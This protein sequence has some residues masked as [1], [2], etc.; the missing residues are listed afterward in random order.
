MSAAVL[1]ILAG[2]KADL[3]LLQLAVKAEDPYSELRIRVADLHA[4]TQALA[5]ALSI[6]PGEAEG[7]R[8]MSSAPKEEGRRILAWCKAAESDHG[9]VELI[10]TGTGWGLVVDHPWPNACLNPRYWRNS[11][12]A[13]LPE[14][15]HHGR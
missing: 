5:A 6:E 14:D 15:T 13:P 1:D 3:D 4:A 10:W 12:A 2:L 8:D 9:V 7:W 11:P